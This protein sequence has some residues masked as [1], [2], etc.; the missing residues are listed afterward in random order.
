MQTKHDLPRVFFV[1]RFCS[2]SEPY[3]GCDITLY[4]KG[5]TADGKI[6]PQAV[7]YHHPAGSMKLDFIWNHIPIILFFK[8]CYFLGREFRVAVPK[9]SRELFHWLSVE[10]SHTG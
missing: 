1:E 6:L 9:F 3:F 10:L 7:R 5:Q 8:M 4:G 2:H